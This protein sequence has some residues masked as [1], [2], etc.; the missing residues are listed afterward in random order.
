MLRFSIA[1]FASIALVA[2]A[3]AAEPPDLIIVGGRVVTVDKDFTIAE[4][5]AVRAGRIVA[6]GTSDDVRKLAGEKSQVVELAGRMLIP[7]LIDSHT[8][9]SGAAMHEFDH[10]IPDMQTIDD[11]LAYIAGR[12]KVVDE[13]QWIWV[14]QVFITRLNEQ[15]FPTRAE[16]D[17]VAPN[18]AVVFRTGPDAA[19]NSKALKLSGIDEDFKVVGN[20]HLE[21][22]AKT[23]KLNGIL[24]ACTRLIKSGD[25]GGRKATEADKQNRL[26][27]LFHD[28][29][30]VGLTAIADRA[31]GG[32]DL[33][34]YH[35][36][37]KNDR[38][39]LRVSASWHVDTGGSTEEVQARIR[40][41]AK[42]PLHRR[43]EMLQLI[44]VKTFLDG[45]MLTGSAYMREPWGVSKIYSIDDPR[46]RGVKFIDDEKLAPI[47]QAAVESNL[48]F[49]AHSVGDGAIHALLDA[50]A[51]VNEN[52]PIA[53]T[54]PC[55][56]HSNFMSAAA[57]DQM[58]KLG[59]VAD[60]QPAWLYSDTR[61]LQ[62]QFGYDR[63][64][65]FQPLAT[66]F[67][68]GAIAGGG[69]DHMQKIG[70]LRS[71]NFYNPFLAMSTAITRRARNYEGQ[72][73]PEEAL[74]R[75]QAIK[76]YTWNNAYLLFQE[77]NFGSLEVG[78]L[79]DMV[80]VDRDLLTCPIDELKDTQ[81]LKTYLG[82][83][84]VYE[85][86]Q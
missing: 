5:L 73:H 55:L 31:A 78:K 29:N 70:S 26:V 11:V 54:R 77:E 4:A 76:F 62:A 25:T 39:T 46:Y 12:T 36:L 56:T 82:G 23:G 72:L 81:V 52:M 74:T 21:R 27:E 71:I 42:H 43:H 44:G 69:S 19:L 24:R 1:C 7:G 16:L 79:A 64:R 63:L 17:R 10:E 68:Q 48:Q 80:I 15:R 14:S 32:G 83:K 75:E 37:L 38:L 18:H 34:R 3:N 50:Y 60:I 85:Q 59:V 84:L 41:V 6:I 49:T 13:D 20:G 2:A 86:K 67:K 35:E 30:S 40:E 53:K 51:K 58:V 57:V 45:G 47:V 9:P 33:E 8:H 61:V 66:I 28:Y 65:Y 22:D